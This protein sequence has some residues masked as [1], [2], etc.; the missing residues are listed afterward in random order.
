[1]IKKLFANYKVF[2]HLKDILSLRYYILTRFGK[3]NIMYQTIH[4]ESDYFC[5]TMNLLRESKIFWIYKP[6]CKISVMH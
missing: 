4:K 1:M 2:N 3:I 6:I 5:R